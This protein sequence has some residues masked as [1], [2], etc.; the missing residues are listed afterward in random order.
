MPQRPARDYATRHSRIIQGMTPPSTP[1]RPP[2]STRERMVAG[3][4]DLISRRGVH[5]TSLRNVVHHTGTPR[6]SL[7]HHFPGGKQ[8]VLEEALEFATHS[9]ATSLDALVAAQG[10]VA[11]LR[12]FGAWWKRILEASD[13][14]AGCPVLAV[15]IEPDQDDA[16]RGPSAG[17]AALHTLVTQAFERWQ[18]ILAASLVQA[19]VAPARAARLAV[20]AVASIEGTVAMCRAARSSAS[21]DDVLDEIAMAFQSAIAPPL[22]P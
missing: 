9:V 1:D 16:A 10:A 17:H 5:A 11:G 21:L 3:A 15:A 6:G 7:V 12:A 20:L 22:K 4:V 8:Q 13:F 2:L 14:Q 18:A 19:G